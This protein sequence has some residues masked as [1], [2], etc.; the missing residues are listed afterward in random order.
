MFRKSKFFILLATLAVSIL[1]V[2]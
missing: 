2:T 1:F